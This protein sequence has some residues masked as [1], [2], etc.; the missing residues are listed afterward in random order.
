MIRFLL[1]IFCTLVALN[2]LIAQQRGENINH[3][4]TD[5]FYTEYKV[6]EKRKFLN[7]KNKRLISKLNPVTYLSAGLLF[8][9]Q[10]V[11]SE[12]I[13]AECNYEISCSGY[14]KSQIE[15][16]GFRGF[17]LGINQLNNCFQAVIYDYQRHQ[18]SA[19][20]MIINPVEKI[21]P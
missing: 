4:L 9:Y 19:R 17:L 15:Q 10:R 2:P 1:F 6:P 3:I 16:N 8:L 13:Q 7:F 20:S 12:Q 11:G 21:D 14:M 18:I 5:N